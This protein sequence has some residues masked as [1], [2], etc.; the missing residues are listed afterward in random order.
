VPISFDGASFTGREQPWEL[1]DTI[2]E[3][4]DRLP[5]V[6]AEDALLMAQL[7]EEEDATGR[8]RAWQRAKAAIE[9]A[10][11]GEVLDRAREDVGFWMQATPADYQGISGLMGREGGHV[12]VRRAAA[13]AVLDAVAA[14][15]AEGDLQSADFDL[16]TRPWRIATEYETGME[17]NAA[18]TEVDDDMDGDDGD[19]GRAR[20]PSE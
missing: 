11:L 12:S 7:W 6:T 18:G 19:S 10:G 1:E 9:R 3:L 2:D 20:A 16:L 13:P 15:L 8:Q 14:L 17:R 4:L 5:A